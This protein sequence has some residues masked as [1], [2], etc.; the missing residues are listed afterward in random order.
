MP[1]I[2]S[3]AL[4]EKKYIASILKRKKNLVEQGWENQ[5]RLWVRLMLT[6]NNVIKY[7]IVLS[8]KHIEYYGID[9]NGQNRTE[10]ER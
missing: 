10:Q 5:V 4:K 8:R 2:F 3:A 6:Q 9:R 1:T 7:E